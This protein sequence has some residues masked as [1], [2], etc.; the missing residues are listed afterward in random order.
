MVSQIKTLLETNINES[1][2]L[3][4][5]YGG[6]IL[7]LVQEEILVPNLNLTSFLKP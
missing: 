6:F 1:D 3:K 7:C 5:Q 4:Y 2:M